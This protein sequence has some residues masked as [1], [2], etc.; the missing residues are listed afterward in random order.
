MF[1]QT[2]SRRQVTERVSYY[3]RVFGVGIRTASLQFVE[4]RDVALYIKGATPQIG[5]INPLLHRVNKGVCVRAQK[6][7][8]TI[9]SQ[10]V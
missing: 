8:R 6:E 4:F 10:A 9:T 2:F 3:S 7:T 5:R 1:V